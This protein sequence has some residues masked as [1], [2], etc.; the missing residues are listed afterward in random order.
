MKPE[1]RLRKATSRLQAKEK[2]LQV[3][4]KNAKDLRNY[5]GELVSNLTAALATL[6]TLKEE[7]ADLKKELKKAKTPKAR[8]KSKVLKTPEEE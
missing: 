8:T 2:E 7:L 6:E 4:L 5:Q 3:A 1:D